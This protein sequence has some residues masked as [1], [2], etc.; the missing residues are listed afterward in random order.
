[1]AEVNL[2]KAREVREAVKN[3]L[4]LEH[5]CQKYGCNGICCNSVSYK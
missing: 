4:G 5:L 2:L 3:G 1:M